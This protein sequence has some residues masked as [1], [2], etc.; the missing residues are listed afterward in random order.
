LGRVTGPDTTAVAADPDSTDGAGVA[1][2]EG[3]AAVPSVRAR[4]GERD[5]AGG[6]DAAAVVV[7]VAR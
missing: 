3:G 7:A 6:T 4:R 2:G 5:A 1:V